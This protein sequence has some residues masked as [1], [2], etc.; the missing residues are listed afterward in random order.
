[1]VEGLALGDVIVDF[2]RL[3]ASRAGRDFHLTHREFELL[4]YLAEHEGQKVSREELLH[5][6]WGYLDVPYTRSVDHAVSRLRK[7]IEVNP[8]SPRYLHTVHGDGY[9]LVL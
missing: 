6:I 7:K 2:V 9:C 5:E 1:M 3:R 4:R 8:H